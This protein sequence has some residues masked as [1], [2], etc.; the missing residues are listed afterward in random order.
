MLES[1]KDGIESRLI[2]TLTCRMKEMLGN[3]EDKDR[4]DHLR[5]EIAKNSK[6][7][8]LGSISGDLDY[9]GVALNFLKTDLK[10]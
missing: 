1:S 4:R 3:Y 2:N 8:S 10:V 6:K 5:A 9:H 7:L